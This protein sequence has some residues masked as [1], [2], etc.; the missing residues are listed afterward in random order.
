MLLV[1]DT[2]VNL[3]RSPKTPLQAKVSV[4]SLTEVLVP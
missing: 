4:R 2:G 3:A 1:L